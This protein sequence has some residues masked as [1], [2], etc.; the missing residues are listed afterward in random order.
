[1]TSTKPLRI[2]ATARAAACL[3]GVLWPG[4]VLAQ[5]APGAPPAQ[6]GLLRLL[7][8]CRRALSPDPGSSGDGR[9]FFLLFRL[10]LGRRF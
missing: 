1:M 4:V 3:L 5:G 8:L 7:F 2:C 10:S 6:R 9:Q